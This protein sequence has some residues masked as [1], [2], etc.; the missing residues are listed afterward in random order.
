MTVAGRPS[1]HGARFPGEVRPLFVAVTPDLNLPDYV[2][3]P[4]L[5]NLP[6]VPWVG[7]D[8][9]DLPD[10]PSIPLPPDQ[11]EVQTPLPSI[12]ISRRDERW[13]Y[14]LTD[15]FPAYKSLLAEPNRAAFERE[16]ARPLEERIEEQRLLNRLPSVAEQFAPSN[17]GLRVEA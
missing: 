2:D 6:R 17:W 8:L 16:M 13:D 10:L 3:L 7:W 14:F 12:D 15:T 1:L 4:D 9:P 11:L 5:P